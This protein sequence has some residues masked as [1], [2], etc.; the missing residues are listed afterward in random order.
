MT[1]SMDDASLLRSNPRAQLKLS[2]QN[3]R[4]EVALLG[5]L[6]SFAHSFS[7][8]A[9]VYKNAITRA[10]ITTLDSKINAPL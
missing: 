4:K 10:N 2:V 7:S 5:D 6:F 1:P 3:G 9:F 8:I